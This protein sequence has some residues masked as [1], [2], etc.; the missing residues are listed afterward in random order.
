[1]KLLFYSNIPSPYRV[2]FF[3]ELGKNCDLTVLFELQNSTERDKN[4]KH[5]EF[6]N[7][8]GIYLKG[9]RLTTDGA[10]CPEILKYLKK[11]YD[12]IVM[13]VLSSPT[14]LLA[15]SYL[16]M[17]KIP[18]CFEGDGGF[19]GTGGGI[20]AKLKRLV[21]S[22]AKACFSTSQEFD[23]YCE[24][25]GATKEHI[26]RYPFT[27]IAEKDVPA[28]PLTAKEKKELRQELDIEE[29]R[30]VLSVG[31]FIHRKGF[32]L[33]LRVSKN[34]P[35]DTG[36]Y[37]VGG[38][39]TEDYLKLREQLE[40]PNVHFVPFMS[41]E[42]LGRY[43]QAADLFVLFTREDI[44]GLVVNEAMAKGLP[45]IST[46]RCIAALEM[47]RDGVNGYVVENENVEEMS[48]VTNLLLE[49]SVLRESMALNAVNC[50]RNE[51]TIEKMASAH[52]S[53]FNEILME[54]HEG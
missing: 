22:G 27:S 26:Y 33:L 4:W 36:V 7:F 30:M 15:A 6:Q 53:I 20:K 46:N 51:Y 8:K 47:I 10:F 31:Q 17:R 14:A 44:W 38:T 2:D 24:T 23:R 35:E 45:V 3:N 9:L 39:P 25:F 1:M 18:Y 49:D 34:L 12:M 50:I 11:D 32:D 5:N 41:R 43:Y 54:R 37:I 16:R 42:E 48:R 13:T 28:K 21:L 29:E 40:L 52:M 19:A